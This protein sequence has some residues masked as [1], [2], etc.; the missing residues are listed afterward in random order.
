MKLHKNYAIWLSKE[1][2]HNS[3]FKSKSFSDSL[4]KQWQYRVSE[5]ICIS[6]KKNVIIS[7][8]TIEHVRCTLGKFLVL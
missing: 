8:L 1:I 5:I 7:C 4:N 6:G 3:R 2:I